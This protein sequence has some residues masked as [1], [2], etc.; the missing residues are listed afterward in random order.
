L[1]RH[2]T[3][4]ASGEVVLRIEAQEEVWPLKEVFRISRG[5]GTI[6]GQAHRLLF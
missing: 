1:P 5:N 2:G 3:A 6:V 4:T